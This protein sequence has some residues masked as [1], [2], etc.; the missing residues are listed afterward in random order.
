MPGFARGLD[1]VPKYNGENFYRN[2]AW[3][4]GRCTQ[5][6][7]VH[8]ANHVFGIQYCRARP[9]NNQSNHLSKSSKAFGFSDEKLTP[10]DPGGHGAAALGSKYPKLYST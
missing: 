6:K 2:K 10:V 7:Y 3:V 9:P 8:A 1:S 5:I 4:L